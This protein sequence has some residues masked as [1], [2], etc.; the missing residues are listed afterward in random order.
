MEAVRQ[1]VGNGTDSQLTISQVCDLHVRAE[2][3]H[4]LSTCSTWLPVR[5]FHVNRNYIEFARS[6]G[7]SRCERNSFRADGETIRRV[8]DIAPGEHLT[9]HAAHRSTHAKLGVRHVGV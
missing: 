1:Q 7:H 5:T 2:L 6:A 8:F 3:A 9:R 4:E